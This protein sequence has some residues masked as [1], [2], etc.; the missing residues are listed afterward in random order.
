MIYDNHDLFLKIQASLNRAANMPTPEEAQQ[1]S[2]TAEELSKFVSD[3]LDA[4]VKE[5]V[6]GLEQKLQLAN[7]QEAPQGELQMAH[8]AFAQK[9]NRL[10]IA[11]TVTAVSEVLVMFLSSALFGGDVPASGMADFGIHLFLNLPNHLI[12]KI[13]E[14]VNASD[15]S[16]GILERVMHA[17]LN[18]AVI[19]NIGAIAW[20]AAELGIT[21]VN[22]RH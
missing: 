1:N 20:L 10:G 7:P 2:I 18:T 19:G 17:I 9:G 14:A 3:N 15:Y 4:I 11:L 21:L 6:D 16:R 8:A 5:V 22:P 12:M 13:L